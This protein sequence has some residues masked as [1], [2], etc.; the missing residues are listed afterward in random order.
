MTDNHLCKRS[1][2]KE[3]FGIVRIPTA[4]MHACCIIK[5][6]TTLYKRTKGSSH[7]TGQ[8]AFE[9]RFGCTGKQQWVSDERRF[10]I[11]FLPRGLGY[12][13]YLCFHRDDN[14]EKSE[15]RPRNLRNDDVRQLWL[16]MTVPLLSRLA[17]VW[18][19]RLRFATFLLAS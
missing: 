8:E 7:A 11:F 4:C 12:P 10:I 13:T 19:S 6:A 1:R 5:T 17:L 2:R 16:L 18:P 3:D 15:S 14:D 9:G